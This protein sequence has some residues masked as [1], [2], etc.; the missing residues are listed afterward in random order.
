MSIKPIPKQPQTDAAAKSSE[1]V[2]VNNVNL[3]RLLQ[4]FQAHLPPEEESINAQERCFQAVVIACHH[5]EWEKIKSVRDDLIGL[6]DAR[7]DHILSAVLESEK[8]DVVESMIR[9]DLHQ[10]LAS[11]EFRLAL[12]R[13]IKLGR[14]D[15][16]PLL[17]EYVV[18]E[19]R[20]MEGK[21]PLF[22]AI[23]ESKPKIVEL[24]LRQGVSI[25]TRF[26]FN[27]IKFSPV[28]WAVARGEVGCLDILASH[29]DHHWHSQAKKIG[30][31]LHIAVYFGQYHVLY[32]LL[33]RYFDKVQPLLEAP[34]HKDQ[35][36][37]LLASMLGDL[38]AI[39]LLHQKGAS[40][41]HSDSNGRTAL[42][43]AAFNNHR[44]C[45]KLLVYLG[46]DL[47]ARDDQTKTPI[48]VAPLDETKALLARLIKANKM[49]H[50]E[51]PKF[52]RTPPQ[53]LVFKGGGPKGI[54]YLGAL[55]ALENSG[56]LSEVVRYAGTSAGAITA[57]LLAVGY[58]SSE[59]EALLK[60]TSLLSFI[61]HP[62]KPEKIKE[63]VTS[64]LNIRGLWNTFNT[65]KSLVIKAK[66]NPIGLGV[67]LAL[68]GL[69]SLWHCTGIC[70]GETFREWIETCIKAKTGIDH[71]T[72]GELRKF[73]QQRKH[74]K[75]LH[76]FGT[77]LGNN[78]E[79]AHFHSEIF[80]NSSSP[81]D[82]L[83]IS[84]IVRLSMSIPGVF[85][86]H[87]PHYKDEKGIRKECVDRGSYVDGGLLNNLPVETFDSRKYCLNGLSPE[88][89]DQPIF[90]RRT[91][92]FSLYSPDQEAKEDKAVET[93]G[94]LLLGIAGV[95]AEAETLIR[96]LNPYNQHRIVE[97]DNRGVGL[98]N[99]NLSEERQND[100]IAS[101]KAAVESFL[102][103]DPALQ[104]APVIDTLIGAREYEEGLKCEKENKLK[105]AFESFQSAADKGHALA[106]VAV[107]NCYF[108]GKGV[109]KSNSKA[110][111]W[112]LKAQQQHCVEASYRL[113]VFYHQTRR[114]PEAL[115]YFHQAQQEHHAPATQF[116]QSL[117][118]INP[119]IAAICG[120]VDY[121]RAYI[122]KHGKECLKSFCLDVH[123]NHEDDKGLALLHLAAKKN[124]GKV[125]EYLIAECFAEANIPDTNGYLAA[126]WASKCGHIE[127]LKAFLKA[128]VP[129]NARGAY[130]RTL[131]HM[132]VFNS[133]YKTTKLLLA[134][135]A[136]INLK[137]ARDNDKTVLYDAVLHLDEPMVEI[138]V[139]NDK[140]DVNIVAEPKQEQG[141]KKIQPFTVLEEACLQGH[142]PIMQLLMNHRSWQELTKAQ[143]LEQ[144]KKLQALENKHHKK[145]IKDF[146]SDCYTKISKL[147]EGVQKPEEAQNEEKCIT[148]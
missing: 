98:L 67:D 80:G 95:F 10:V 68:K 84:D 50:R 45:I 72:F 130:D 56:T 14:A 124:Q 118:Y 91:L 96:N 24:L 105:E 4:V 62:L 82:H 63:A 148:Q 25:K 21:T 127:I 74:F 23:E 137:A 102:Q 55:K 47:N 48:E 70:E 141:S 131:L 103:L 90:N 61:D 79:I 52:S 112:Y 146:L 76:L 139:E 107:G 22:V 143:K 97:I 88:E 113:G 39:Y 134:R 34:N 20:D 51:P 12:H 128:G 42:H 49:D 125:V 15:L 92:G 31:L 28:M 8:P 106:Q 19:E 36:P 122:Q 86:P 5:Q 1:D 57:A 85:K 132:S 3:S 53:N 60:K 29:P 38:K 83:I 142:L 30:S 114:Y 115:K 81:H 117:F 136:D 66:A 87:A 58:T 26:T 129:V 93:I 116:L 109:Q 108:E 94:D 77:K 46:A 71:C 16:I 135:G 54:A 2:N 110:F 133:Q 44:D 41:L 13:A 75:H 9:N 73:I 6:R 144:I 99:F 27:K 126:H 64:R 123:E 89:Q 120:N 78:P 140:L 65:V 119:F 138:L 43:W 59:V 145:M 32:H 7:G 104:P 111:V 33:T 101:G 17:S 69:K 40:H 35:T 18:D 147:P 11:G 121:L 100:L 37:L